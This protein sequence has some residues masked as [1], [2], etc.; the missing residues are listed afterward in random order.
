MRGR[1]ACRSVALALLA[2]LAASCALL[3]PVTARLERDKALQA[4]GAFAEI[5]AQDPPAACDAP[6]TDVCRQLWAIRGRACLALARVEAAAGAACPP[7][8][9]RA[10]LDCAVTA[11]DRAGDLDG[12]DRDALG[13]N[14]A[15]AR[16][17]AAHLRRAAEALALAQKAEADLDGLAP[18]P[19]RALIAASS[20]LFVAQSETAGAGARC[21][22]A[23][24]AIDRAQAALGAF[25]GAPEAPALKGTLASAIAEQRRI[26]T[27]PGG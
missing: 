17:C 12:P 5:V 3:D 16:Y 27:C 18:S 4:R 14:R 8:N 6:A 15:R 19:S 11:Y 9:E 13:E 1:F 24:R 20:A 22:A 10:R 21:T 26:P 25:P 7:D 2:A 23:K